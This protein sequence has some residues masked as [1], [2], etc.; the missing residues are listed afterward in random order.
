MERRQLGKSDPLV[1]EI[2]LGCMGM[3]GVYGAPD[4]AEAEATI[5]RAVPT[6]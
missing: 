6:N 2:G 4:E 5:R 3:S 1:V